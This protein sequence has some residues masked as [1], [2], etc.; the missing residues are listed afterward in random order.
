MLSPSEQRPGESKQ[1]RPRRKSDL[2]G[3]VNGRAGR[4]GVYTV[5]EDGLANGG[6]GREGEG[7]VEAGAAVAA[8]DTVWFE[9]YY[10]V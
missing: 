5:G 9:R 4:V 7:L 6:P 8:P 2:P 10:C 3:E 1:V